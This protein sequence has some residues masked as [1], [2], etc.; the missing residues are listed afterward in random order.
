MSSDGAVNAVL[1]CLIKIKLTS[2]TDF[3]FALLICSWWAFEVCWADSW[4]GLSQI[5]FFGLL[6]LLQQRFKFIQSGTGTTRGSRS[7]NSS[8][9][10]TWATPRWPA[11]EKMSIRISEHWF[12][13]FEYITSNKA[14]EHL[15]QPLCLH[16]HAFF[17]ASAAGFSVN[18]LSSHA[19]SGK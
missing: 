17:L 14:Q 12:L 6:K 15:V 5:A 19:Q 3:E 9:S 2:E 7:S 10:L 4:L 8:G 1:V 16:A 18:V 11:G 13:P